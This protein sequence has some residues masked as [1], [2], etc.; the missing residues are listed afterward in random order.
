VDGRRLKGW[1]FMCPIIVGGYEAN[2]TLTAGTVSGAL[3]AANTLVTNGT[4]IIWHRPDKGAA[5]GSSAIVLSA[6]VPDK[7]SSLRSRRS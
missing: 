6:S 4:T 2:G 7:V 3:A 5:N 1:T